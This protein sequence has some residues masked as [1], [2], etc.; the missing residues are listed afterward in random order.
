[1]TLRVQA[2][3]VAFSYPQDN[4]GLAPVTL[5]VEPGE[6]LLVGG[7]SGC[8]KSTLAR[9]LTGLI[10]HL[11][12]GSFSGEVWL[13]ELQTIQ[14][15]LW[16]I[17]ERAGMV[18]QNPSTQMLTASVEEEIVFGL[19]NLGLP[20]ETVRRRLEAA[21]AR[22]GLEAFRERSPQTLSGGEQ[23]KLALAAILARQPAVVALDE[24]FSM[25]DGAAAADLLAH[26]VDLAGSGASVIIC[27]HREDY[28]ASIAALRTVHLGGTQAGVG[29]SE[30][31]VFEFK[32]APFELTVKGLTVRLGQRII[33]NELGFSARGGELIAVV[34]RN[35]VGKTTLLRAM[36]GLQAHDGTVA[37]DG[38]QPGLGMVFQNADLQ[39]FNASVRD[40]VLYRLP[41]PDLRFYGQLLDVLGLSRYEHTPPLLLSEGEK[42]R[43]AL[44]TVLM[45]RPRH[46]VLLDEPALGQDA[47]HKAML[48]C[49]ARGLTG[50]GQLVIMTTHDLCLAAQADRLLLMGPDGLVADGPPSQVMGDPGPWGQI[51]LPRPGRVHASL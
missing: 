34:G 43:V 4:H 19:E 1:L 14:S 18:F 2:D 45:R 31:P 25:L 9:C 42:K 8:G 41:D 11:Y 22:F 37:V 16:Q 30:V 35:G 28:L 15:P 49:L 21:L 48:V 40:E 36:I 38:G 46:G 27:E 50:A 17:A 20:S 24:P 13:D 32:L 51:G 33:L 47:A 39:L 29:S 5:S 3:R 10:P 7:P 6:L 26:L 12:R 44:A 23:Q